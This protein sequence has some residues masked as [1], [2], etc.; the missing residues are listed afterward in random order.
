MRFQRLAT[1]L[2]ADASK[3]YTLDT[4]KEETI[5]AFHGEPDQGH[6]EGSL[7]AA[8]VRVSAVS[9]AVAPPKWLKDKGYTEQDWHNAVQKA[10]QKGLLK[11]G[12]EF[13]LV[14]SLMKNMKKSNPAAAGNDLKDACWEGYEA[15]GLKD[16]PGGRKVPNCVPKKKKSNVKADH[17]SNKVHILKD[18]DLEQLP[19]DKAVLED[20]ADDVKED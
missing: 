3:E 7:T 11:T 9:V 14:V 2:V 4:D 17:C 16:G 12:R 15:Y 18:G 10:E 5:D 20:L 8:T 13:G 1:V 6:W 19:Y